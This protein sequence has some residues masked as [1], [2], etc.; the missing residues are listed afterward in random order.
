[1]S[2]S[3]P[4]ITPFG[5]ENTSQA[6]IAPSKAAPTAED[7]ERHRPLIK[8]LY[9][10][11]RMK[12]KDVVSIMSTQHGHNATLKMYKDRIRKWKLEK[13]HKEGD[14][15]AILRKQT[16]R[17]AVGKES[18]FRVR[19][20][21]V[22]IEEVFHYF[23]RKKNVRDEEA[24][25][26]PTPSDVSCRTPSPAPVLVAPENENH[27]VTTANFAWADLPDQNMAFHYAGTIQN[28]DGAELNSMT[29]SHANSVFSKER[30][31]EL[32]LNDMYNLISVDEAIPQSLS[33]P[34]TLLVPE[35]LFLAIKNYLDGGFER[36]CWI[37]DADGY[38]TALGTRS[39]ENL[40]PDS[41]FSNLCVS[42]L[43]LLDKKLLVEFRRILGKAFRYVE[44]LIRAE[45]PRTLDSIIS[46]MVLFKRNRC[47]EIA[48]LL[49][50][51]IFN[52]STTVLGGEHLWT[53]IWRL[54]G[55]LE[56]ESLEQVLTQ[57]WRCTVDRFEEALGP[58]H[59][60][61]LSNNL[62]FLAGLRITKEESE[63]HLR[64][65][66]VRCESESSIPNQQIISI[67]QYL[68]W[69]LIRQSRFAEAE[70][71]GLDISSRAEE[72]RLL[73]QRTEALNLI[74]ESQYHQNKRYLAEENLRYSLQLTISE[75]GRTDQ[76]VLDLKIDLEAWLREWGREDE[77]E[78]LKAEIEE[79]IGR[80]EIDE[81]LEGY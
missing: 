70:Q 64:R 38:C 1:M 24:Y 46:C 61:S 71:L 21:P 76:Y 44:I 32:T 33:A 28:S 60:S 18:S 65:L 20:Q 49:S 62:D 52:I 12:L 56:G 72:Q 48:E 67:M 41:D 25:N 54:I 37:T 35:R 5:F 53:Q 2:Y 39:L 58:F 27:I 11:E 15:L 36:G 77:A 8:S 43:K 19:D 78:R 51:Y 66:L 34:Q 23:K 13:K 16:E 80:D 7:W 81:E 3:P 22:T 4:L 69:N 50:R 75:W 29:L 10:D 42:A 9:V 79:V 47:P 17:N 55:M 63:T 6:V 57:L 68:G 59:L 26:A 73:Y 30:I 45:H 40:D 74:A 14:M 31:F